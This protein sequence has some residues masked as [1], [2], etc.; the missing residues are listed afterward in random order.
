[1][2]VLYAYKKPLAIVRST[3]Q[4]IDEGQALAWLAFV[5]LGSLIVGLMLAGE[6]EA[7][8]GLG[9]ISAWRLRPFRLWRCRPSGPSR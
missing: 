1:M 3:I 9:A 4:V 6:G 8:V 7:S 2:I 5:V